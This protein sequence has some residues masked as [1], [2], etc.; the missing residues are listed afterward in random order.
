MKTDSI[1][2]QRML[3]KYGS[4]EA[5]QEVMRDN[6][7]KSNGNKTGKGGFGERPIEERREISR[8]AAEARWS[9]PTT[10]VE[11]VL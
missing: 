2:Y 3:K 10:E 1:W 7:K 9:K 5:I 8:K 6:A 4:D 11:D